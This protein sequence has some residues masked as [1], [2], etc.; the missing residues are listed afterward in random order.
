MKERKNERKNERKT[1]NKKERKK[2][3][4]QA[5]RWKERK[6]EKKKERKKERKTG[7]RWCDKG[8]QKIGKEVWK[9]RALWSKIEKKNRQNSHLIN[10]FPTSEGVSEVSSQEQANE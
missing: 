5:N 1:E 4:R 7:K 3:E 8:Y 2:Y 10:H 6:K 9:R